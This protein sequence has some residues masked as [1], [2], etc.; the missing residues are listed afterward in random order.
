MS[1]TIAYSASK[2]D[3]ISPYKGAGFFPAGFPKTEGALCAEMAR[4]AYCRG[5]SGFAFDQDRIVNI[6]SRFVTRLKDVTGRRYVDCGDIVTRIP[7]ETFGFVHVGDP[8]YIKLDRSIAFN[9]ATNLI[10]A[11]QD[12]AREQYLIDYAWKIG[13]VAV[14]DL[15]D[16][17]PINYVTAVTAND[18][19]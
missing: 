9:P 16:H 1:L 19:P 7:P 8:Y 4:L 5:S 14:R 18:P 3:L 6:L 12:Q 13:N 10:K 17:A 2:E 11:D 15:A